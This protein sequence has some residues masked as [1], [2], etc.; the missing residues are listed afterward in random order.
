MTSIGKVNELQKIFPNIKEELQSAFT[1]VM[2][3]INLA[4]EIL[5]GK[6]GTVIFYLSSQASPL[7]KKMASTI[8]ECFG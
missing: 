3:D 7:A 8:L 6:S 4:V 1:A 2:G 5:L